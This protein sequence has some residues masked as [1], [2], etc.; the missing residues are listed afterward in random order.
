MSYLSVKLGIKW[1]VCLIISEG[2]T[3][4]NIF[5]HAI[6]LQ[7]IIG[8]MKGLEMGKHLGS[9]AVTNKTACYLNKGN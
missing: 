7:P 1:A 6:S 3:D 4:W 5:I 9:C 8:I 2:Y